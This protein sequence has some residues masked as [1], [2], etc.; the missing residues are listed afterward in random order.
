VT[1][2]VDA[3]YAAH[4][5]FKSHTGSVIKLGNATM[6]V[7]S[8]KQKLNTK[9][10]TEAEVVGVSDSLSQ[11]VWTR[12]LMQEQGYDIGPL[13]LKQDDKSGMILMN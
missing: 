9:S 8:S 13:K 12:E 4:P 6:H 7:K 2:F 3:S 11:A 1:A 10:S 5:D